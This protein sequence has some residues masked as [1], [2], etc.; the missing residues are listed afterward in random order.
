MVVEFCPKCSSPQNMAVSAST[1]EAVDSD[2]RTTKIETRGYQCQACHSFVRSE[3][4][5]V[6]EDDSERVARSS[7]AAKEP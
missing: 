1:S 4:V 5:D 6:T 7:T 3:E 2:G